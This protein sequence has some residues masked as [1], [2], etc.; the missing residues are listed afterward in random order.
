MESS[1]RS[2]NGRKRTLGSSELPASK[3]ES[4]FEKILEF[5]KKEILIKQKKEKQATVQVTNKSDVV[6]DVDPSL[7]Q[8]FFD[9]GVELPMASVSSNSNNQ[10]IRENANSNTKEED[11]ETGAL[12]KGFFDD[13]KMDAKLQ[14]GANAKDPFEEQMEMFRKEIAQ[15]SIVS[16]VI[17]EEE[18][19]QL[20]KEKEIADI[21][22]QMN[23]WEKVDEYQKKIEEV[24]KKREDDKVGVDDENDD[25]SDQDEDFDN[26]NDMNFWRNKGAFI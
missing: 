9:S 8:D 24:H 15:E 12:P 13:P 16:E 6:L 17:L 2:S 3:R 5:S 25:D 18:I 21:E 14:K 11:V 10:T 26:L 1:T 23:K 22:E 19:E 20:Q 4:K 7:P